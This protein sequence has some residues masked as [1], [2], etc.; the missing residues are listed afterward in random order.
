METQR[1]CID[2]TDQELSEIQKA[3]DNHE[4]KLEVFVKELIWFAM[5]PPNQ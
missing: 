1:I 2:F 5:K 3:A 4:M